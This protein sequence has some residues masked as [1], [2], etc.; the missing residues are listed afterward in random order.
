[1]NIPGKPLCD[2][3]F[4]NEDDYSYLVDESKWLKRLS[5]RITPGKGLWNSVF[6]D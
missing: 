5:Y 4:L 3:N 2:C 1:M 6:S